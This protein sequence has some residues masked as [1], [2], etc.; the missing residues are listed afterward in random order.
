MVVSEYEFNSATWS[1]T[2]PWIDP[3]GKTLYLASNSNEGYGGN[4]LYVS[5]FN[6]TE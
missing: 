6:G 5:R 1:V 4:D 2:N 3:T